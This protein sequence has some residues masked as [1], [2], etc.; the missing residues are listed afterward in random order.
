[1]I[2]PF[3]YDHIQ[4]VET[5]SGGLVRVVA[6]IPLDVLELLKSCGPEIEH[7][8]RFIEIRSKCSRASKNPLFIVNE[9]LGCIS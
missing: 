6:V 8:A 1:M 9:R 3:M 5:L 2:A 4:S 7:A